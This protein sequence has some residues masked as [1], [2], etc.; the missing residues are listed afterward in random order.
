MPMLPVI[1]GDAI[2][3]LH[4]L[5]YTILLFVI[6]LFPYLTG[7]SGLIYLLAAVSLGLGFLY[8]ALRL[9]RAADNKLA[10]KTFGYSL[11]YL[12]GLFSALLVDHYFRL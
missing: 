2:T 12:M 1:Y 10:M 11:F 4:I 9:K 7:M 5:L 3:K 8:Y 6:S